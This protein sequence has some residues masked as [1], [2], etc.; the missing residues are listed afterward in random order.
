MTEN[1]NQEYNYSQPTQQGLSGQA[2]VRSGGL[3]PNPDKV[4]LDAGLQPGRIIEIVDL[5]RQTEQFG[6][7]PPETRHKIRIGFEHPQLK[8]RYYMEDDVPRSC[9]TSKE[10]TYSIGDNSFLKKVIEAAEKRPVSID[11][12]RSLSKDM[13]R[14]LG[15]II[16]VQIGHKVSKAG[17]PYEKVTGVMAWNDKTM[18]LPQP[19][20]PE[21]DTHW[22]F[23]DLDPR[24]RQVIGNNFR[25]QVFANLPGY[26]K[27]TI[28]RSEEAQ[29]YAA[30]GGVF[31]EKNDS[32]QGQSTTVQA[33]SASQQQQVST[34]APSPSKVV[35]NADGSM[36]LEMIDQNFTMEQYLSS[37]DWTP[38]LMVQHGK[39]R[40]IQNPAT[41]QPIASPSAPA[42]PPAA[43]SA[44][45]SPVQS[46][47]Q[48]S[49]TYQ[50]EDDVPF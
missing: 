2:D 25:S 17:N 46:P 30:N 41:Q 40:W 39:A 6:N 24:T 38:E 7:K 37:P 35:T 11:E 50:D 28:L 48:G 43:P 26:V 14:Y 1:A 15:K 32:Q 47:T 10:A 18:M 27:K 42:G 13:S 21:R 49:D 4:L 8:Q 9:I 33:Q 23:I 31:A 45:S 20:T 5:G 44:P 36:I 22:F 19:W 12:A 16:G 3:T 34:P 29:K